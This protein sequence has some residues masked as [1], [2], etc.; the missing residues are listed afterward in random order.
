VAVRTAGVVKIERELAGNNN[1]TI[2]GGCH[3]GT[4]ENRIDSFGPS[5]FLSWY[6]HQCHGRFSSNFLPSFPLLEEEEEE[7]FIRIQWIL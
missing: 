4:L 2:N 7:E 5:K 3:S 6:T 1:R